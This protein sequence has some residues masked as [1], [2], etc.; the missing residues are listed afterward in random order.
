MLTCHIFFLCGVSLV[1]IDFVAVKISRLCTGTKGS[2]LSGITF[3][4]AQYIGEVLLHRIICRIG[5]GKQIVVRIGKYNMGIVV[6]Q[7]TAVCS[8]G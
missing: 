1:H 8:C 7:Q 3:A 2:P 5:K 6:L 4:A